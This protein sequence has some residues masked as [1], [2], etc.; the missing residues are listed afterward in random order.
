MSIDKLRGQYIRETP[1]EKAQRQRDRVKYRNV[2]VG[3]IEAGKGY[4]SSYKKIG[5]EE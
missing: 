5:K 3:C 2:R 1:E 4:T